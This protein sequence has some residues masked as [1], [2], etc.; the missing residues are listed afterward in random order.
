[1]GIKIRFMEKQDI[2]LVC[3]IQQQAFGERTPEDFEHCIKN[4]LYCYC[5]AESDRVVVGYFGVMFVG[6]ESELLTI[7]V[8]ENYRHRGFGK[9]LLAGAISAAKKMGA[10]A[11]FLEVRE[12]ND[13][14]GFYEHLGFKKSYVRKGYY[15]TLL[16]AKD[17]FVMR[18]ELK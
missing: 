5:V 7:A 11:M 14:I 16:G 12:D 10:R 13:A 4:K 18:L 15:P 2:P 6:D 8:D 3:D 17:A 9:I 1:M